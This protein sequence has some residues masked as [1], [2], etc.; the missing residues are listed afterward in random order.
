MKFKRQDPDPGFLLFARSGSGT[1]TA[2]YLPYH[3]S[4]SITLCLNLSQIPGAGATCVPRGLLQGHHP[5]PPDHLQDL[6]QVVSPSIVFSLRFCRLFSILIVSLIDC[7]HHPQGLG[8]RGLAAFSHPPI[9][10]LAAGGD[11]GG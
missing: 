4:L 11:E 7:M 1:L 5:D 9:E 8:K 3:I 2:T 10:Y 6:L